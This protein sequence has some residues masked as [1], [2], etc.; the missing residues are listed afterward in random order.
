MNNEVEIVQRGEHIIEL[1]RM[2]P[3][4]FQRVL[5]PKCV[6]C[7]CFWEP[8][9]DDIKSSGAYYKSCR[10][11]RKPK[12]TAEEIREK[13]RERARLRREKLKAETLKDCKH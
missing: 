1:S 7:K 6:S 11:C 3:Y 8:N 9:K 10:R 5:N 4:T 2:G 13:D 12:M